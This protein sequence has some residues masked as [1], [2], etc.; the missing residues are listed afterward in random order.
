M[1]TFKSVDD[2]YAVMRTF[3]EKVRHDSVLGPKLAG[4]KMSIR[5]VYTDPEAQITID[6][7]SPPAEA[8]TYANIDYGPSEVRADVTMKQ[9]ADFSHKFWHGKTNV[10]ASLATRQII[11]SGSVQK[12]LAL[13]PLLRPVY[14]LYPRV[15]R[16]MGREE[17]VI[18]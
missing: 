1:A 14:D 17:L 8:G 9:S 7:A 10:V 5:F 4:S 3:F 16:E 12:A 13:L 15:L 6:F 2:F 18:K 11:A